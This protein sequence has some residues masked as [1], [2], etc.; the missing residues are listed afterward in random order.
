MP[1]ISTQ[2]VAFCRGYMQ[3]D[4]VYEY[5]KQQY[6]QRKTSAPSTPGAC[7]LGK[8]LAKNSGKTVHKPLIS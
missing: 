1:Y 3:E 8:H 7:E 2:P 5:S 6:I 4:N